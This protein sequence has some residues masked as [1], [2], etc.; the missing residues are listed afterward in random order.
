LPAGKVAN[1]PRWRGVKPQSPPR[2]GL[3]P[4]RRR[5]E[6]LKGCPTGRATTSRSEAH[7]PETLKRVRRGHNCRVSAKP[8]QLRGAAACFTNSNFRGHGGRPSCVDG[9]HEGLA[10]RLAKRRRL[11]L[12]QVSWKRSASGS[13]WGRRLNRSHVPN[14]VRCL[15]WPCIRS[16]PKARKPPTRSCA[17]GEEPKAAEFDCGASSYGSSGVQAIRS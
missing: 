15:N 10:F 11:A 3:A 2:R 13:G 16:R 1:R 17:R 8:R 12:W 7:R 9:S 6:T 4:Q 14:G 5:R